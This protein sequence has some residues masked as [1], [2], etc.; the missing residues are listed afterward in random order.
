MG[1]SVEFKL[2]HADTDVSGLDVVLGLLIMNYETPLLL[3]H[4]APVQN[5]CFEMI[6]VYFENT[7]VIRYLF[8]YLF[9]ITINNFINVIIKNDEY[10]PQGNDKIIKVGS[11]SCLFNCLILF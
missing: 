3:H 7:V 6:L 2:F 4:V 1:G 5:N 8:I 11:V 10:K 9:L